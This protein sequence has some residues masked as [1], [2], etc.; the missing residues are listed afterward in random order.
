MQ[1][2]NISPYIRVAMDHKVQAPWE[3]AER[4][5]WDYEMLYVQEGKLEVNVEGRI[6]EGLPGDVVMLKPG[7]RHAIRSIGD[8]AVRQPHVHFDLFRQLDSEQVKVSFKLASQMSATERQWFRQDLLSAGPYRL[9][10]FI[11]LNHPQVFEGMLHGL[12]HEY[13]VR[14]P[15][16]EWKVQG[17]LTHLLVHLLREADETM[18]A[19]GAAEAPGAARLYRIQHFLLQHTGREVALDELAAVFHISKFHLI[20][21][22]KQAFQLT[23]IQYHQQLRMERAR[24]LLEHTNL[25]LAQIGEQLGYESIHTFSR[26]YKNRM[27][28]APSTV[29]QREGGGGGGL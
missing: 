6:Y 25:T 14:A 29:R 2:D 22:F 19:A 4:Q 13:Q 21:M 16:Y 20:R 15:Y 3:I 11:R 10:D 23:P 17:Q 5:I 12:I 8:Q 26:A 24:Q 1:L 27:G 28:V 7:R 18:G 9:P